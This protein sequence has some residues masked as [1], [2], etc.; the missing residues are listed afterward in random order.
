MKAKTAQIYLDG[1]LILHADNLQ[2]DGKKFQFTGLLLTG[3]VDRV[4]ILNAT[5]QESRQRTGGGA[6]KLEIRLSLF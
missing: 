4:K 1:E 6:Q 3:S 2:Y 5:H